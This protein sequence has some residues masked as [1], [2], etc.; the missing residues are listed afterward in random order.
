M[1]TGI[2]T[3][4]GDEPMTR[5]QEVLDRIAELDAADVPIQQSLIEIRNNELAAL[6]AEL[7]DIRGE[8]YEP[9]IEDVPGSDD[10]AVDDEIV[11]DEIVD[12]EI[13]DDMLAD[14]TVDAAGV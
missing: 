8:P 9:L 7:A 10:L 6:R 12:D 13:V 11:D 4:F 1:D 14:E 3:G 2:D 5:E